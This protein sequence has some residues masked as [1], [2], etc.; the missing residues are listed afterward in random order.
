[1]KLYGN[2]NAGENEE[3]VKRYIMSKLYMN[4]YCIKQ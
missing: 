1:M 3:H 4:K 2:K